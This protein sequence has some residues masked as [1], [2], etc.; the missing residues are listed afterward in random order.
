VGVGVF[1]ILLFLSYINGTY[2]PVLNSLTRHI[3][4]FL[5]V[6]LVYKQYFV[7][8]QQQSEWTTQVWNVD[9]GL[10]QNS[11]LTVTQAS[12]GF[13]FVGTE[14]GLARF[15]GQSF[16][17]FNSDNT[18]AITNNRI[19]HTF[20]ARDSTLWLATVSGEF[21]AYKNNTFTKKIRIGDHIPILIDLFFEDDEGNLVFS[22]ETSSEFTIVSKASGFQKFKRIQTPIEPG[23]A[24]KFTAC[25]APDGDGHLI[26][27][28]GGIWRFSKGRL[29]PE[30]ALNESIGFGKDKLHSI[31]PDYKDN[32]WLMHENK[33]CYLSQKGLKTYSIPF[34]DTET[35]P[36]RILIDKEEN[37][38]VYGINGLAIK[39]K[40]V[41]TLTKVV[42]EV[43]LRIRSMYN[44][45]EGNIWIGTSSQG[46]IRLTKNP[47]TYLPIPAEADRTAVSVLEDRSDSSYWVASL[48]TGLY[49][50]R[51]GRLVTES[52]IKQ[53]LKNMGCVWGQGFDSKGRLISNGFGNFLVAITKDRI[54]KLA[55]TQKFGPIMAV[56]N[57]PKHGLLLGSEFG[58]ATLSSD[59][60]S[61]FPL[62]KRLSKESITYFYLDKK[63][64]F[65]YTSKSSV[66]WL[67]QDGSVHRLKSQQPNYQMTHRGIFEGA[68]GNIYFGTD[69]GGMGIYRNNQ[70]KYLTTAHGLPNNVISY[71][72]E[73]GA[74]KLILSTNLGLVT[75]LKKDIEE[76]FALKSK[77]V[78]CNLYNTSDGLLNS[79]FNGGLMPSGVALAGNKLLLPTLSGVVQVDLDR[80]ESISI[81]PKVYLE[82]IQDDQ[83][84]V[85]DPNE[86]TTHYTGQRIQFRYTTPAFSQAKNIRFRFKLEGYDMDWVYAGNARTAEYTKVPPGSY[87]FVVQVSNKPRVWATSGSELMLV[88]TPPFYRTIWFWL[89]VFI[90]VGG[91]II[92]FSELRR[93]QILK[94]TSE[95][96]A[97][98]RIMPD[99]MLRLDYDGRYMDHVAGDAKDLIMPFAEMK[100][101]YPEEIVPELAPIMRDCMDSATQ[102]GK[103]QIHI[104]R[105]KGSH[106]A[107]EFFEWRIVSIQGG[108][109]YLLIVRNITRVVTDRLKIKRNKE[110]L[111][112]ALNE[113][114]SLLNQLTRIE[115]ARMTAFIDAQ[116]TERRRIA[117]DLH[118][119]I[120]VM[121]ST[122]RLQ[123]E[124]MHH[125]DPLT[126]TDYNSKTN[127]IKEMLDSVATEIRSISFDLLPASLK[128]FGLMA[129]LSDL[130]ENVKTSS[131]IA[132]T[133]YSNNSLDGLPTKI[134]L[135]LY[136][137]VQEALANVLKHSRATEV[138][139]QVID[140]TEFILLE[141]S[142]NGIGFN[143]KQT[144]SEKGGSGLKNMITRVQTMN[145]KLDFET[146]QSGTSLFVN[147]P[148]TGIRKLAKAL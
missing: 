126:N 15:D 10:P 94:T 124:N 140:H 133:L 48:C 145:G 11:V 6:L 77:Q 58:I 93:K 31:V 111:Q 20:Q 102:T 5:F 110:S 29:I 64:R 91:A 101:K 82:S 42:L 118:D 123:I 107:K 40:N 112:K 100:G 97:L 76:W 109:G 61:L 132:I 51:K 18:P 113:K 131:G 121:I 148:R 104:Y 128:H 19:R 2:F 50:V 41:D 67:N 142:D 33:L 9:N 53:R 127:T 106:L 70:L 98:M 81:P 66:G 147:I 52:P 62:W 47:F 138:D 46:L 17:L 72:H 63:N 80:L 115:N 143:L 73:Y 28:N 120:G 141:I 57:H 85:S 35:F 65:W 95:K 134:Q 130:V 84:V 39:K 135:Y 34:E 71:I 116:E 83:K 14:A 75:L 3:G 54:E 146:G 105:I 43:P 139:I 90:V 22:E 8:G 23:W 125:R 88:I 103:V 45:N 24:N 137:I 49:Q 1:S 89:L 96:A 26:A 60:I 136:R 44:D 37:V 55:N 12:S 74:G 86:Y 4:L 114:T 30:T 117:G 119:S 38:W 56:Y 144:L 21:I 27:G 59:S 87:R 16:R 25:K 36:H 7:Y 68:S 69:G 108:K 92:Y 78:E 129:A 32:Y 13:L 122:I 79:E 99:L